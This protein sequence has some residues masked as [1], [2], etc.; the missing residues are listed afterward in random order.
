MR[1]YHFDLVDTASVT[2]V[3]GAILDDDEHA[4]RIARGLAHEVREG[5]PELVGRGY[6][7]LVRTENGNEISRVAVDQPA[8]DG[9]GR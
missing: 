6:E 3:N 4:M 2:D 9:N 8:K 1:R 5:R 7:V